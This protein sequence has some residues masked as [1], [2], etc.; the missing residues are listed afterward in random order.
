[1]LNASHASLKND[2]AVTGRELDVLAETAQ[3]QAG[4]LGARMTGAGF[5]GCAIAVVSEEQLEIFE[6]VVGS[7]YEAEIG[8][9][10]SF[11]VAYIGTGARVMVEE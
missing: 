6:K 9:P 11:Y 2:Y 10:A 8:Y 4:C 7:T 5:G 3:K 1:L